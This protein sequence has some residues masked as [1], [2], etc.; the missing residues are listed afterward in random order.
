MPASPPPYP[1]SSAPLVWD[2][3]VADSAQGWAN[4]CVFEHSTSPFGENLSECALCLLRAMPAAA[5]PGWR[6]MRTGSPRRACR[7]RAHHLHAS[8]YAACA[9]CNSTPHPT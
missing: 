1:C 5:V 4:N 8:A 6:G 2:A 3:T 9:A 7:P